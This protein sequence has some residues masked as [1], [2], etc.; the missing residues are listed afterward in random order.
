MEPTQNA[1]TALLGI[2]HPI[3]L[4]PFGGGLSSVGMAALVSSMGGLG[5]YGVHAL[6]PDDI[7]PI[8][9]ELRAATDAPFAL[10]LWVS[11]HDAGGFDCD[12]A[13]FEA[14]WRVF[15]P[16]FD[17]LG[18]KRP[19]RMER[20][21]PDFELQVD[22]LLAARPPAFSFIFGI[23]EA[24][25]LAECRRLQI[26]TIG[27][28]TTLAEA[29]ALDAA[30]V[31]LI[32]ASGAEAGG[33]RPSFLRSAEQSLHGTFVLT[34]L[35]SRRVRAP[36]IAAGGI[37]DGRGIRAALQLGAQAA[38]IGTAFLACAESGAT[39]LHRAALFSPAARDTT[40]TRSFTGRLARG[41]RNRWTESV[42][43]AVLPPFPIT[44][45]FVSKL[46]SAALAAGRD[47]LISLWSGQIA[48]NLHHRDARS[49]MQ[50]LI[51]EL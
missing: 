4:G 50:S 7:G 9:D 23:P 22:A 48:P 45:W 29:E 14:A 19:S 3:V 5:S 15:R 36:V 28:A 40:L 33:H 25:V 24:R 21:H 46:R 32:V 16:W 49:L 17:E 43:A 38:Q 10:N 12:D 39:D 8:A 42:D 44:S 11:D 47:D 30:G 31:D 6:K 34:Q 18:V 20:G 37:A 1:A 27:T 13:T 2:R 41:L 51:D 26:T 35:V